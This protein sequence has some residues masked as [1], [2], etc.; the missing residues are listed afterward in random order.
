MLEERTGLPVLGVLPY[1]HG[2]R[3][4]QEDGAVLDGARAIVPPP[5]IWL[6][7]CCDSR[8]S[9]ITPISRRSKMNLT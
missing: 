6:P 4:P 9:R 8:A 1:I 2:L 5:A 7:A 3:I